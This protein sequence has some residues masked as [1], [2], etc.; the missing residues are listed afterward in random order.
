VSVR[1]L[2]LLTE[3]FKSK[4]GIETF[5]QGILRAISRDA[6]DIRCTAIVLN[7]RSSKGKNCLPANVRLSSCAVTSHRLLW[8]VI[9]TAKAFQYALRFRPHLVVCGHVSLVPICYLLKRLFG[10][11]YMVLTYGVEV[12][13][14]NEGLVKRGLTEAR[15]VVSIS[16]YT[17]EKLLEQL[18]LGEER[19]GL[20]PC[21]VDAGRF[22][23]R[24]KSPELVRRYGLDGHK[25]LL[26]VGRLSLLES[27]KGYDT[28]IEAMPK[29]LRAVPN[30]KYMLVGTGDHLEH[31]KVRARRLGVEDKVIF[32]GFIPDAEIV[33]H[34]NLCDLFVMPSKGEGFGIVYLEALA[35]GKPVVAGNRDGSRDALLNGD[36]GTLVNPDDVDEVAEAILNVLGGKVSTRLQDPLYLR[37][38]VT[39]NFGTARFESRVR[40]VFRQ[41]R[42][43]YV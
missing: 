24:P 19:V 29:M 28:V 40:E 30:L 41:A 32:T 35:C 15:K 10:V 26:T 1:Y 17:K 9:F 36:L 42:V 22:V 12:W 20:L 6:E 31:L 11:E 13:Q 2:F 8:K 25:V 43:S 33:D 34:Y 14:L 23:P 16:Q 5:N 18:P 38:T 4:G 39:V 3:L 27:Y 37:E 21:S 7:D